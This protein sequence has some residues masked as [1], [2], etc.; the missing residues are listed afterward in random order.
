MTSVRKFSVLIIDDDKNYC[1]SL[2]AY[3]FSCGYETFCAHTIKSGQA[4]YLKQQ[5]DIVLLDQNLPDGDGANL[6]RPILEH[7]NNTKI[8]FITA[9]PDFENAVT[10]MK[11]GAFDYLS[12]PINLEELD[13]ILQRALKLTDLENIEQVQRYKNIQKSKAAT[14]IGQDNGLKE[15]SYLVEMASTTEANVLITGETG[16]GKNVVAKAIHYRREKQTS[17]FISI[18]CAALPESLIESELF[19][20]EKGAFTGATMTHKGVFEM[21]D[22]GTLFLDEIGAMPINLQTKLLGV[23][24][25]KVV[26]RL[27]GQSFIPVDV[28]IIA[29]TNA[30]VEDAIKHNTFR[31]DL[32]YRLNV[33]RIHIPTLQ[34]RKQDIPELCQYFISK[35]VKSQSITCAETEIVRLMEYDWPGNVRELRNIIE[36]SLVLCKGGQIKPAKLV[37]PEG[38]RPALVQTGA[39]ENDIVSL[40]ELEREHILYVFANSSRNLAKTATILSVSESTL[41]RKLKAYTVIQ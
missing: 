21:A 27:G 4:A 31:S 18:N 36:R 30:S 39:D 13:L 23:L 22:G 2:L 38:E 16:V 26:K 1:E 34:E 5:I 40:E 9:Y 6:C 35:L 17:P 37:F 3:L 8:I 20:H 12:K 33:I 10:A 29:A 19:G 24:E 11:A 25:D 7:N 14:L 32:Y 41:R 15:V 28:R